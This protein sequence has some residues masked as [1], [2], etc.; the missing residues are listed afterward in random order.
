MKIIQLPFFAGSRHNFARLIAH[1]EDFHVAAAK[2][3]KKR[4]AID[5]HG[6]FS[7]ATSTPNGKPCRT[8]TLIVIGTSRENEKRSNE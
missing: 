1:F 5:I 4:A 8:Q 2:Y 6:T 3:L 7:G